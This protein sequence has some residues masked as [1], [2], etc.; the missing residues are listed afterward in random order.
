MTV[1]GKIDRVFAGF[2]W[3]SGRQDLAAR[4][5][6]EPSSWGDARTTVLDGGR[7]LA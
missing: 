5:E 7:V 4:K 1:L 3:R 2:I 6:R